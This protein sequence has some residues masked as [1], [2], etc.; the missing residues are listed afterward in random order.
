[1]ITQLF[2]PLLD[3]WSVILLRRVRII[4][5]H[6][7]NT[8]WPLD[9]WPGGLK[10]T[11][12][13]EAGFEGFEW[14]YL[15]HV[16]SIS[17]SSM[18]SSTWSHHL[19]HLGEVRSWDYLEKVEVSMLFNMW[20][21]ECFF[22]CMWCVAVSFAPYTG[23]CVN[24]CVFLLALSTYKKLTQPLWKWVELKVCSG[25]FLLKTWR[26]PAIGRDIRDVRDTGLS[27]VF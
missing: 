19:A 25:E 7:W 5:E 10:G 3:H 17:P 21:G 1:M 15:S 23:W 2:T 18:I 13:G 9:V 22:V 12:G 14:L 26:T 24:V 16:Y 8:A 11:S 20:L 6:L 27:H 4:L